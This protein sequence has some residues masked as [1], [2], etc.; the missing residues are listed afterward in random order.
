MTLEE[1]VVKA[2]GI[3]AYSEKIQSRN[4]D[5]AYEDRQDFNYT[6]YAWAVRMVKEY[7]G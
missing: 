1:L 5:K 3:I 4:K 2:R 7:M 6:S